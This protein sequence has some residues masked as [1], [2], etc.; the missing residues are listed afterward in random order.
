MGETLDLAYLVDVETQGDNNP[1]T[2]EQGETQGNIMTPAVMEDGMTCDN[3][4]YLAGLQLFNFMAGEHFVVDSGNAERH[5]DGT[6]TSPWPHLV[7]TIRKPSC[8]WRPTSKN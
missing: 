1:F 4:S 8:W 5:E 7:Q 3:V 2:L 6:C